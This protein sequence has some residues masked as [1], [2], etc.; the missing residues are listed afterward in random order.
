MAKIAI[1]NLNGD[2]ENGFHATLQVG[3]PG[4]SPSVGHQGKLPQNPKLSEAYRR[5][6]LRYEGLGKRLRKLRDTKGQETNVSNVRACEE[7]AHNLKY[8]LNEWLDWH[9]FLYLRKI[10]KELD[11]SEEFRLIIQNNE[12]DLLRKLPWNLWYLV[13]QLNAEVALSSPAFVL[14][15]KTQR[16]R[17]KP[18]I[19]AIIG[20]NEGINVDVDRQL[21]EKLEEEKNV[22]ITFLVEPKLGEI[23][24]VLCDEKGWDILF[25]AGH[26]SSQVDGGRG[27][28]YINQK[29]SIGISDLN[30]ALEIAIKRG[31]RLAIFNSCEGLGLV[32]ELENLAM[33]QV[34]VMKEPVPDEV[35]QEFLKSFL[36]DFTNGD[37]LYVSVRKAR[38]NLRKVEDLLPSAHWLPVIFQNPA[39]MPL[40]W[41]ELTPPKLEHVS[42]MLEYLL[43]GIFSSEK[44][45][46]TK[47][48]K[49]GNGEVASPQ[50]PDVVELTSISNYWT[51]DLKR[52]QWVSIEG[53]L[54]QYAP[55]FIGPPKLKRDVHRGYRRAIP[56]DDL[57]D[58]QES[59]TTVDANLSFTAGQMVLRLDPQETF[60]WVYMGLYH[61]IIRNSIPIFVDKD[62]Y[63]NA[64]KPHF[65]RN[66][67]RITYVIEV[68]ITGRLIPFPGNFIQEYIEKNKIKSYIRPELISDIERELL[69]IF[70]DGNNT[71]IEYLGPARY[72]DGDIWVALKSGVEEFFVSRFIDL[73]DVEDVR[74]E[75][76]A[77]EREARN[78]LPDSKVIYQFDQVERLIKGDQTVDSMIKRFTQ[79]RRSSG[80]S[81]SMPF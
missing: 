38:E 45:L 67:N 30:R 50:K 56:L 77:L 3:E 79:P 63:T 33:P 36:R 14:A 31:L 11:T 8:R 35:A 7:A 20:N 74:Q 40:T 44:T 1:L 16:L 12:I 55:M 52:G 5:W 6:R 68:K 25:F 54:S 43:S 13:Q 78:F 4:K 10:L 72:L 61:S 51:N 2:F 26:G 48:E 75:S 17:A 18:R 19:L 62:Y 21:L 41:Q 23:F 64:V 59:Q 60:N 37:S 66:G 28:I 29:D 81:S 27:R 46:E 49:G 65:E 34:I 9:E 39:E 53:A 58:M 24:T 57:E 42:N 47:L 80:D 76:Q 70:I 71:E 15:E 69:A 22:N 32:K 73:S